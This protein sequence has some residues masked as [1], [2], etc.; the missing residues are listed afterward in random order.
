MRRSEKGEKLST[1]VERGGITALKTRGKR[2][3]LIVIA[4]FLLIFDSMWLM[5]CLFAVGQLY[6]T[7]DLRVYLS[8]A[9]IALIIL[10]GLFAAAVFCVVRAITLKD[11][12]GSDDKNEVKSD[13][14]ND[15]AAEEKGD[16]DLGDN[17]NDSDA[18][19][20]GQI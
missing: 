8:E 9:P 14:G 1:G 10:I 19:D 13:G 12:G 7:Y 15:K 3:A 11:K 2:I 5:A 16:E 6:D 17:V 4:I 18:K 20:K